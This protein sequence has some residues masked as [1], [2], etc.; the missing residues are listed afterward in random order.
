MI[1]T[2]TATRERV[3]EGTRATRSGRMCV[4]AP[5]SGRVPALAWVLAGALLLGAGGCTAGHPARAASSA[6]PTRSAAA[7]GMPGMQMAPA[8]PQAP[9]VEL[10]IGME[11]LFGQD[12]FVGIRVTRSLAAR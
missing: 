10:R 5:V 9:A 12:V 7:Q 4:A 2:S 6:S 1:R 8:A 3:A 11:E